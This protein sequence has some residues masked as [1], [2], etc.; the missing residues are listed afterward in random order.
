VRDGLAA[1]P[2]LDAWLAEKSRPRPDRLT[3][4]CAM[5]AD[6][7]FGRG[8]AAEPIDRCIEA[9]TAFAAYVST[10]NLP[11][12]VRYLVGSPDFECCAERWMDT[13][14][15]GRI[16]AVVLVAGK[17][18]DWTARQFDPSADFPAITTPRE[19]FGWKRMLPW[20]P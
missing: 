15:G 6:S 12:K 8:L 2:E 10:F 17:L 14:P 16:H 4:L 13:R 11:A 3:Q 1:V 19:R 7:E 5:F 20:T 18:V 9:S